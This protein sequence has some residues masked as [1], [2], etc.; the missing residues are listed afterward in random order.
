MGAMYALAVIVYIVA[1]IVRSRQGINL[2]A[3]YEE[4]PVD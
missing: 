2:K 1:R 3:I 4:I